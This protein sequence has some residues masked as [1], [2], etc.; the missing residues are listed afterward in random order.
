MPNDSHAFLGEG[1]QQLA[2]SMGDN[3]WSDL[4][5]DDIAATGR[6]E[7]VALLPMGTRNGNASVEI[8]VRTKDGDLIHA[9]TTFALWENAT[10]MM[11]RWRAEPGR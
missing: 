10:A 5:S 4:N 11:W 3:C 2:V 7:R 8:L 9:N 1:Q 6:I